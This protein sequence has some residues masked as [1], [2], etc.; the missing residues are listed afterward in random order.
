MS[1]AVRVHH[2]K[3]KL[4]VIGDSA[5]GKTSL[6][7]RYC[8][9]DFSFSYVTTIGVDY[10]SKDI[11]IDEETYTLEI[12][13][14]AGQERFRTITTS[15]YRDCM[16]ILLV[17][18]IDDEK[19]FQSV[20]SWMYD[21]EQHAAKDV[22][23]V[24]VGNKSDLVNKRSVKHSA[25]QEVATEFNMEFFE[26]SA[27]NKINVNEAFEA[28]VHKILSNKKPELL[29]TQSIKLIAKPTEAN[30]GTSRKS[31]TAPPRE[32]GCC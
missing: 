26:T 7:T 16:G 15:F 23:V 3:I 21:I 17:Y 5:V 31:S 27:M 18:S 25:A 30:A 29:H 11:E 12:W 32:K 14:T 13:D 8:D 1:D 19:S 28:A 22:C 6:L 20:R 9:N 24:L 10:K 2:P 4:L